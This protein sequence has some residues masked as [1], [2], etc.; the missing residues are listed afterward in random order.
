[1]EGI[2]EEMTN[3]V[4]DKVAHKVIENAVKHARLVLLVGAEAFV[5]I[6]VKLLSYNNIFGTTRRC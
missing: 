2:S 5:V 3:I 4:F 6:N 1:V